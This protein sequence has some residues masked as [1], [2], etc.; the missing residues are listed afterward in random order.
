MEVEPSTWY[1]SRDTHPS[2]DLAH[3]R[4]T[5]QPCLCPN[6]HSTWAHIYGLGWPVIY[7]VLWKIHFN[8]NQDF[9]GPS[10]TKITGFYYPRLPKLGRATHMCVSKL[11]IT[12]SNNRLSPGRYQAIIWTNARIL[13][14][15]P[16]GTN[17]GEIQ[18]KFIHFH[19]RKCILKCRLENSG[20]FISASTC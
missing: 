20:H 14:I 17:F 7:Q 19:S 10:L 8:G 6:H 9:D 16:L 2:I 3:W 1:P 18:S 5:S 13:L 11:T 15:G 12:G 4:L